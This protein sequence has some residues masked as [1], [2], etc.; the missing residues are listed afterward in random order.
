[1]DEL[2]L[3]FSGSPY[4][5]EKGEKD[6][7]LTSRLVR[8]TDY[9]RERCP[10]YGRMLEAC[11]V[12][13]TAEHYSELPFLPVGLFKRMTLSSLPGGKEEVKTVTSSG[14]GGQQ[15]SQIILDAETR[16]LQQQALAAIAGDFVGKRRLPMLII[17]C[18][19][20]LK[21]RDRYS[22]RTTGI[23]GFS[24]VGAHRTFALKDDFSLDTDAL[25]DFL[26]KYGGK[27]FLVFGFTFLV[28]EYFCLELKKRRERPDMS[29]GILIHGGGWKK[30]TDQAVS[31]EK[32]RSSLQE[33]C[34][35]ERVHDYYGMAEQ[36]GSIFM[37]CECG[38]LHAS[39]YSGVLI[40]RAGDF[41]LCGFG[42]PGILQV[43]SVLPRSYPGHSLITEDE[44]VLL[45]EDDCP[46]GRKGA[47]FRVIGR[48][49][50]AELRGCSDTFSR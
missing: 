9:H 38:H 22:A 6:R 19:S 50:N 49:K 33:V 40:R 29:N 25:R 47:Y 39:D 17:D 18:P 2:Q 3:D 34:G 23:L 48:M 10:E 46:C 37:E 8:L 41:S 15:T 12:F 45:G 30:L 4:R 26:E 35:I 7:V 32:F 21:K 44:G 36:T 5:L 13:R 28:W 1:M 20:T 16:S 31:E 14:T 42:E 27:T 43:L 11:G 24:I